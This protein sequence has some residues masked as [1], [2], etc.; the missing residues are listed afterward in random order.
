MDQYLCFLLWTATHGPPK[1][2]PASA[3]GRWASREA[4]FRGRADPS[5]S[6]R[7]RA[8][9]R[10]QAP[11]RSAQRRRPSVRRRPARRFTAGTAQAGDSEQYPNVVPGSAAQV[12]IAKDDVKTT[13]P[14]ANGSCM[15]AAAGPTQDGTTAPQMEEL[16]HWG[17]WQRGSPGY[18]DSA[19]HRGARPVWVTGLSGQ[20]GSQGC[21]A[22]MVWQSRDMYFNGQVWAKTPDTEG[23]SHP[24]P[25]IGGFGLRKPPPQAL[26]KTTP[27]NPGN[28]L[29]A[30]KI[31]SFINQH[32]T[33]QLPVGWNGKSSRS[34][35]S[36]GAREC[37]T[38]P[39]CPLQR[40]CQRL[41][42]EP[43]LVGTQYL[44]KPL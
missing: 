23:S 5:Q 17:A 26:V 3:G 44:T 20:R 16:G 11:R 40:G 43:R 22:S 15:R 24:P 29:T 12:P 35:A 18:P 38:R 27:G 36:V 14:I 13:R 4:A 1:L 10:S 28:A 32:S 2:N 30:N 19:G 33:G 21:P 37:S 25:L 8:E 31:V 9:R 34:H 41:C 42:S 7:A 39:T 6:M